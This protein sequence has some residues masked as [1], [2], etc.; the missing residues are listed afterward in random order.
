M[1]FFAKYNLANCICAFF[2]LT[3]YHLAN[4][5]Y[6]LFLAALALSYGL[7]SRGAD[8]NLKVFLSVRAHLNG[9]TFDSMSKIPFS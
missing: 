9:L 8:V 3:N 6:A 4:C 7:I 5:I 1:F 2:F